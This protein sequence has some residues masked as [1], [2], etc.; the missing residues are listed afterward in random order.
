MRRYPARRA[1][2]ALAAAATLVAAYP[3]VAFAQEG[4]QRVTVD[5]P[6]FPFSQNKQNEPGVAINPANP[7]IL[8]AGSNEEIDMEG[9]LAGTD[10]TCPFTPGVGV[11]GIYFSLD[12]G[13]SWTQPEYQGFTARQ[14]LGAPG[15]D[16][17]PCQGEI[18]PI[19][20]L[21]NYV[22]NDM[23]SNGDPILA[24][25]P[26]P[27]QNGNFAWENGSRLYYSNIATPF[28]GR[29]PFKGGGAI[30]VS[31]ADDIQAA[32]AGS[33]DAW[34]DPVI[35][36]RQNSALFSDKEN[37]WVD[38]AESSP[39]FGTV[40]ECN[41][42]FRGTAGSEPVLV[43]VSGDGGETWRTSQVSPAHNNGSVG[44][45]QFCMMRTDSQGVVYLVWSGFDQQRNSQV[46]FQIRSHDGGKTW[47]KPAQPIIAVDGI[48]QPDPVSGRLTIDGVAGSRTSVL[49]A[50]DIANGA[51]T[52]ENATDEIVVTWSDA[53]RGE[54]QERAFVAYSKDGG[55]SYTVVDNPV[56]E[57]A[58]RANQ[59][60]IA[61][62]P[63]GD[64]VYLVYN[65]FLGPW[66]ETT[67]APRPMLGVVRQATI[68]QAEAGEFTTVHRGA[69]G[70]ARGSSANGLTG[71]FLGDYNF[72][73][74]ADG[75][76]YTVWNDSRGAEPCPAV[77]AYRQ[78]LAEGQNAEAPTPCQ[79][80]PT[81][82][83]DTEIFGFRAESP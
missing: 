31:H 70:D 25:G 15:P 19:G 8:A 33:N 35:V 47:D 51:P 6:A 69:V 57:G 46:F 40:Y 58:D 72:A 36:T 54:N 10:N 82:F 9:C 27:D 50:I 64:N 39:F 26:R 74:A 67:S 76:G 20:T 24:F 65:A 16:D 43:S 45:R 3:A 56:S 66:E 21:P 11:S 28:P 17:P 30:A 18:G 73:F 48:G 12:G 75:F 63:D 59:P 60:A 38:N 4:E 32:A 83:G 1:L 22:E 44:G 55:D 68:G 41:V 34:S 37:L 5:N 62:E 71:E 14:C 2:V 29:E 52:G 79:V 7:Q 61:I 78:A 80:P 49:P 42:G 77:N 23:V 13:Q 81:S 53:R